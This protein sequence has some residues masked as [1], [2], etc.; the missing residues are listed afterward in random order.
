MTSCSSFSDYESSADEENEP[1]KVKK[2]KTKPA[3]KP[4][5]N[6]SKSVR[7]FK[8]TEKR[9]SSINKNPHKASSKTLECVDNVLTQ[10]P[11]FSIFSSI[12][13]RANRKLVNDIPKLSQVASTSRFELNSSNLKLDSHFEKP[14][15]EFN[16][17]QQQNTS[18]NS[19]KVSSYFY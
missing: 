3:K 12:N 19:F 6:L 2:R 13:T 11:S 5:D 8:V 18:N 9:I 10:S 4:E 17:C 16:S 7:N 1:Q 14:Y 15:E